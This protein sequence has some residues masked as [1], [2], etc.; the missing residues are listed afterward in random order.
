MFINILKSM[1]WSLIAMLSF[2]A[3]SLFFLAMTLLGPISFAIFAFIVLSAG[4]YFTNY[5]K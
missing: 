5:H 2:V 4:I 3:I 1:L